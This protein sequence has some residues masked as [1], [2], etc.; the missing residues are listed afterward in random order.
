MLD[1]WKRCLASLL[2]LNAN[3]LNAFPVD[4]VP[5]GS[6]M[7]R[8]SDST[9][10]R[11]IPGI[12][13]AA[14]TTNAPLMGSTWGHGVTLRG[15]EGTGRFTWVSV[16]Y[17]DTM[18]IRLLSGRDFSRKDTGASGRVAVVNQ[19]FVRRYLSGVNPLGQTLR[20]HSEPGYPST[21]YEIVGT[22]ADT[23]YESLRGDTPPMVFAPASQFPDP[24]PWTTIMMHSSLPAATAAELMYRILKIRP[25]AA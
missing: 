24:R 3:T 17:F 19:T 25:W 11:N 1:L 21:V 9:E 13:N 10:I 8:I 2:T 6:E 22:I 18:A 23:K 20:T 14:S 16:G 7:I 12:E 15:A 4:K 5:P